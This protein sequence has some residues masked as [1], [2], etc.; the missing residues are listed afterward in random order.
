MKNMSAKIERKIIHKIILMDKPLRFVENRPQASWLKRPWLMQQIR[1]VEFFENIF[2]NVQVVSLEDPELQTYLNKYADGDAPIAFDAE[3]TQPKNQN[4]Y[5]DQEEPK[6]AL[7]QICG[8][9][10]ALLIQRNLHDP[11]PKSEEN[12]KRI[13]VDFFQNHKFYSKYTILDILHMKEFFGV[14]F[15][16]N[17]ENVELTR[18]R[19]HDLSTNFQE[20]I[21][22]FA[23]KA[24]SDFLAKFL[25]FSDWSQNPLETR[26]VLY[27]AFHVVGLWKSYPS[28]PE[29]NLNFISDDMNCPTPIQYIKGIDRFPVNY[30]Y[31]YII[32]FNLHELSSTELTEILS[33]KPA[34]IVLHWFNDKAIAEVDKIT[35]FKRLLEGRNIKC[36]VLDVSAWAD[37][38]EN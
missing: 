27:A 3:Y 2:T 10:G 15:S 30:D 18:I 24:K 33:V 19:S 21:E 8:S 17:I 1:R 38:D 36:G 6:I 7:I 28:L 26:Q 16:R 5:S 32:M 20:M 4:E 34:F 29:P 9:N 13:M 14:S 12:G 31:Q 22:K 37:E 23:G 11:D 35:G 25:S